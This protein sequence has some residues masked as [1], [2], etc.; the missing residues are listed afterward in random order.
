VLTGDPDK[1]IGQIEQHRRISPLP[2]IGSDSAR[3][4]AYP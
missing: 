2:L 1:F 3:F 4:K